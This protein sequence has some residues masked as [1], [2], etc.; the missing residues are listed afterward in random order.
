M[1]D[2]FP[3]LLA[4]IRVL[5]S[6]LHDL[7]VDIND[8]AEADLADIL[9]MDDGPAR[10]NELILFLED[11]QMAL[12]AV[13]KERNMTTLKLHR[14]AAGYYTGTASG[15]RIEIEW[16]RTPYGDEGWMLLVNGEPITEVPRRTRREVVAIAERMAKTVNELMED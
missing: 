13:S 11:L 6:E 2:L 16:Q 15:M 8:S 10:D 9:Q 5:N 1:S 4:R 7:G 12:D 3:Q 14:E